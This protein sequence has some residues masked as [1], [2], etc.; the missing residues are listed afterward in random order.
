MTWP[1]RLLMGQI[2]DHDIRLIRVFRAVADCGGFTAAEA[3]LGVAKSTIS[4]QINELEIRIGT[5]LCDRGRSGFS[6]TNEGK[7][8]YDAST[9]L[10]NAFEEFRTDINNS[11]GQFNI[12]LLDAITT[13]RQSKLSQIIAEFT[14]LHPALELTVIIGSAAE[15]NQAIIDRRIDAAVSVL[16]SKLPDIT[17]IFLFEEYSYLYCGNKHPLFNRKDEAV[18]ITTLSSL[19]LARHGY[20]QEE[21][22][23]IKQWNLNPTATCNHC[24]ALVML[25]LS[26]NYLGFLPE[27]YARQWINAGEMCPVRPDK[28]NKS[29]NIEL[30][31]QQEIQTNPVLNSLYSIAKK[32]TEPTLENTR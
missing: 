28:I 17:R 22:K 21:S 14:S 12:G 7:S 30:I 4:K 19:A 5:R 29:T 16:E 10:L 23:I 25:I 6:L 32:L 3:E 26:G 11:K 24:E 27:H 18:D 15:L 1:H 8:V 9:K 31:C 2:T 13:K 20:S